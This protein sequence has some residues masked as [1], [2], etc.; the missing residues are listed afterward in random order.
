MW[1]LVGVHIC[2]GDEK[3]LMDLQTIFGNTVKLLKSNSPVIFTALGVGGVIATSY[4]VAKGSFQA[5]DILI[6]EDREELPNNEKIKLIW[7]CY[8]PAVISGAATIGCIVCASK[9]SNNR[10][11]AAMA[12][13]SLTERAFTEYREKVSDELGKGKDQKVLDEI[14]KDRIAEHPPCLGDVIVVGNGHVMCCEMYTGRYFRSDMDKLRRAE[15]EIN[16]KIFIERYVTLDEFYELIDVRPTSDSSRFGWDSDK[17]L[18]LEFSTVMAENDEP[19][20][21][22]SYNYVKPL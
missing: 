4:F 15:N 2:E 5:A 9:A 3:A 8:V 17:M 6:D 14:A 13:Y 7:K 19:C 20:I 18:K 10:A 1:T 12:A 22:F 21:A 16:A 11:V